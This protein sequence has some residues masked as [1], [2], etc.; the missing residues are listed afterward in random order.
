MRYFPLNPELQTLVDRSIQ[1]AVVRDALLPSAL[2]S[3]STLSCPWLGL[4][5]AFLSPR[6]L[7]SAPVHEPLAQVLQGSF[8]SDQCNLLMEK[9]KPNKQTNHNSVNHTSRGSGPNGEKGSAGGSFH[10]LRT[11]VST[12]Q[13]PNRSFRLFMEPRGSKAWVTPSLTRAP[14]FSL[15]KSSPD[16]RPLF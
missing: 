1:G 6:P 7:L 15:V 13:N 4:V 16:S 8:S 14:L 12:V 9:N 10:Q 11:Q 2:F 3:L 5:P